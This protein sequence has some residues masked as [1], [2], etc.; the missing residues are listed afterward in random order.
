MLRLQLKLVS[1]MIVLRK[2][3]NVFSKLLKSVENTLVIGIISL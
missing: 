1:K 2:N 3:V